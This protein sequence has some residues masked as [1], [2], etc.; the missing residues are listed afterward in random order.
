MYTRQERM[1]RVD[2]FARHTLSR[3]YHPV[4]VPYGYDSYYLN[5]MA[6]PTREWHFHNDPA[7]AWIIERDAK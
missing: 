1:A 3:G 2:A 6:G 7:H 4:V 5:V